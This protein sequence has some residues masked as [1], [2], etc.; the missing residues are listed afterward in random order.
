VAA[1][2]LRITLRKT[3]L[4][5]GPLIGAIFVGIPVLWIL[6]YPDNL[7]YELEEASE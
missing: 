1:G 7:T 2:T 3:E 4:R 5:V 6:G